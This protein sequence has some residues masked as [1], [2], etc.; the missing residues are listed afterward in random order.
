MKWI[1]GDFLQDGKGKSLYKVKGQAN[2]VWMEFKDDL[3][4]FNG[5]KK[6]SFKGKG[7]INRDLSSC[8]F[9]YLGAKQM[10][11]HW[12]ENV[13]TNSMICTYIQMIPLEVV[14]RNRLA[15]STAKR[16][17]LSEGSFISEPLVELFYKKDE[18]GDPFISTE[19]AV[20]LKIVP[21][22]EWIHY[23][24]KEALK[25]NQALKV[26]FDAV[27]LEIIDFKLEFGVVQ[28]QSGQSKSTM[29]DLRPIPQFILGDEISCD[30]CRLWDKLS[31]KKMDKDRFRLNLGEVQEAY[32][33][34]YN[35]VRKKWDDGS[36]AGRR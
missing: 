4:A 36:A 34:V 1:K 20:I 3:T 16:F 17:Q 15:G 14:V 27:G 28:P 22:S 23:L 8:I 30:S 29:T 10:T 13:G 35:I 9:R 7:E 33:T 11:H 19:Q 31:G 5:A 2:Y 32:Q 26:F 6:D 24:Q 21:S 18:L 12:I 25:I